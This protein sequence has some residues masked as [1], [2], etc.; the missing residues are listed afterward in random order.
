MNKQIFPEGLFASQPSSDISQ[1]GTAHSCR[2]AAGF[3]GGTVQ[4]AAEIPGS[5]R[6]HDPARHRRN[7][8]I[9]DNPD[10]HKDDIDT[11]R[12]VY[13][14]VRIVLQFLDVVLEHQ[15]LEFGEQG[16]EQIADRKPQIDGDIPREPLSECGLETVPYAE[17]ER[18]R[19]QNGEHDQKK[20]PHGIYQ[21]LRR[22]EYQFQQA[23]ERVTDLL[24]QVIHAHLHVHTQPGG[25]IHG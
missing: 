12:V 21:Q 25:G 15:H 2:K 3:R 19:S 4:V 24:L 13:R 11:V 22:G 5:S 23:A 20:G 18:Y 6:L 9:P 1:Y 17:G 10:K 16:A 14:V 7:G 8:K